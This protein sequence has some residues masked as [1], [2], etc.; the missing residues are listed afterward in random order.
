MLTFERDDLQPG[1]DQHLFSFQGLTGCKKA[2]KR[3]FFKASQPW[4]GHGDSWPTR[5]P[6]HYRLC[7]Y[8]ALQHTGEHSCKWKTLI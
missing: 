4:Q 6:A 8:G 2:P 3:G 5:A 1:K 7:S